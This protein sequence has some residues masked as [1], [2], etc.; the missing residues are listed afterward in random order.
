MKAN[1]YILGIALLIISHYQ[2]CKINMSQP[3]LDEIAAGS[4]LSVDRTEAQSA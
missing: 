3:N 4:V 2:L 1:V